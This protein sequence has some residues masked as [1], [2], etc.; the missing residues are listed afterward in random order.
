MVIE[1]ELF[2]SGD[3]DFRLWGWI[4]GEGYERKVDTRAGISGILVAAARIEKRDDEPRR[5]VRE[6][7]EVH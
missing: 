7:L 1:I 3:A 6:L 5:T 2:E 4:K